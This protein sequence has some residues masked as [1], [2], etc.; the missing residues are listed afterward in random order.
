MDY[1]F[2]DILRKNLCKENIEDSIIYF[3]S[4][5]YELK[6]KVIDIM[7]LD[8]YKLEYM[9][10]KNYPDLFELSKE[11][12]YKKCIYD[13]ETLITLLDATYVFNN[14]SFFN[15]YIIF[16]EMQCFNQDVNLKKISNMHLLDKITYQIKDDLD[17]YK[18]YYIDFKDKT[19]IELIDSFICLLTMRLNDLKNIDFNKYKKIILEIIQVYYKWKIFIKDHDGEYLLNR[20]DINY[21]KILEKYKLDKLFILIDNDN[22]FLPYMLGEYLHYT[23]SKLEINENFVDDYLSKT[24]SKS[25][26]KKFDIK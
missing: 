2:N 9:C 3:E 23:T 12:I 5:P 8:Y 11:E 26:K 20:E 22:Y 1:S 16:K 14:T 4:L 10:N 13:T 21:I 15:K 6:E 7:L 17:S 24:S 25:L 18:E 19:P